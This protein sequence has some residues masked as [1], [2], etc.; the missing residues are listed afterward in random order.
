MNLLDLLPAGWR[1]ALRPHL[2]PAA[3]AA[4]SAFVTA[5]YAAGPVYP[6]LDDLFAAYRLCPPEACRGC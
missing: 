2:D 3:T 1:D 4:L 6:P 5:E